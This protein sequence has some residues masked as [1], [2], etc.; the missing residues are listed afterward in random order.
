V[1][2]SP[3]VAAIAFV[4]LCAAPGGATAGET[5]YEV[6]DRVKSAARDTESQALALAGLAWP[7]EPQEPEVSSLA[8]EQL[9]HFGN[10]GLAALRWAITN[11][12]PRFQADAVAALLESRQRI[13]DELPP[14]YL[15]ALEEAVWFA[16][17]EAKRLA[18]PELSRH[19]YPPALMT[20]VDAAYLHTEL[21]LEIVEALG[22]M[23]SDRTRHFLLKILREGTPEEAAAAARSLARIGERALGTLRA[24]VLDDLPQARVAAVRALLPISSVDDL[25]RLHDFVARYGGDDPAVTEKAR[26]RAELLEM[27]FERKQAAEA[28][29]AFD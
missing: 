6:V 12:P 8:R 18:V 23:E 4:L 9:I 25:S 11:A 16:S 28:A 24:A 21:R 7:S 29:T 10:D 20:L 2:R 5:A 3:C 17:V 13:P 14:D 22:R 27:V 15:P 19:A 26:R 1:F